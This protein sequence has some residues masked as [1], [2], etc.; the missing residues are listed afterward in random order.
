M[1]TFK[2]I[3]LIIIITAGPLFAEDNPQSQSQTSGDWFLKNVR[4]PGNITP[5]SAKEKIVIAVVDDGVRISHQDIKDFIWKNPQE[6]PNNEIDDDGNGYVDDIRG[7]DVSDEDNDV[8]PPQNRLTEFYHGTHIAGIV[9]QITKAAYGPSASD[10]IRIMPVKCLAD[11]AAKTYLKD[12]YKGIDYAVKNGA[13]I[14]ICAWGVNNISPDETKIL[15]QA[16]N[17]GVSIVASAGNF[18][19]ERE[20]YPAAHD[21]VLAVA[22]LNQK[23]E[24]IENSNYGSFIDLSAPGL[25]ISSAGVLSDTNYQTK[26]GSSAA[27]A[28][29]AAAVA[30]VKLQHPSYSPQLIKACLKSSAQPLDAIN[31]KFAA[32][33]GAGRLN[34]EAAVEGA[35]FRRDTKQENQ[36]LNPQGYLRFHNPTRKSASWTIKPYG[37]F[38]GLRFKPLFTKGLPGQSIINFYSDNSADAKPLRSYPLAY[39]PET[40]YIP[41]TSAYVTFQRKNT[42]KQLQWLMEYRAEPINFSCLYCRGTVHL[43]AEGT[44]EDG[45]GANDYSFNSDCKWLITAP[46]GKVIH[47]K[48]TEFHTEAKTDLLYFFNGAGTHEKIMA[49]YSG[50]KIPPELTTWT[51]QTLVWFVTDGKNQGKGW[52]AQYRFKDP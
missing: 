9:A 24:K 34:I 13:D 25:Y 36:L 48:F 45:S 50:P 10:Y 52:K 22:A 4:V 41:G 32:K 26:Q 2:L 12:G 27:T 15:H 49:I 31:P 35:L 1:Q 46:E 7:W 16:H 44:F 37:D 42:D 6:I 47:I 39:L 18:P 20:Q 19:E 43:D 23:G 11:S 8:T 17:K 40:I 21:T 3:N 5:K 38:K 51:N 14:I 33:L 28:I 30:I 29:A